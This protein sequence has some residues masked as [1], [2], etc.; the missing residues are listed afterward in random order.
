MSC[1]P[2]VCV[3]VTHALKPRAIQRS[4]RAV[5]SAA[6]MDESSLGQAHCSTLAHTLPL[7]TPAKEGE[8]RGGEGARKRVSQLASSWPS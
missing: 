5:K 3:M 6:V 8:A 4:N 1:G 2:E 7:T